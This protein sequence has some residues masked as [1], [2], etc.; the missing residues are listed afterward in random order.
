MFWTLG[1]FVWPRLSDAGATTAV[2][3]VIVRPDGS[4]EAC[5]IPAFI[6]TSGRP[7][8]TGPPDCS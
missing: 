7:E 1:N 3:Q 8:L 2:G 5:M 6:T 4:N